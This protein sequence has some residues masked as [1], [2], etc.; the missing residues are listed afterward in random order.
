MD[1]GSGSLKPISLRNPVYLNLGLKKP[2]KDLKVA[3][4]V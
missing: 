4:H 1:F 2:D 3:V